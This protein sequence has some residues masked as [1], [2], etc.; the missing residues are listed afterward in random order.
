MTT[1]MRAGAIALAALV[2]GACAQTAATS[3]PADAAEYHRPPSNPF[4]EAFSREDGVRPIRWGGWMKTLTPGTGA[5]PGMDDK[6]LVNYR[7]ALIDGTEFDSSYA[8]GRP[9]TFAV[10]SVIPCWTNGMMA[11][12]VGE[13]AKFVCPA[14]SAYGDA[15]SPPKIPGGATLVFEIELLDVVK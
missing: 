9:S 7:G 14:A 15:G 8:R 1:W 13:K 2:C 6:V 10:T 11:M 5:S 4:E 3:G 12:R